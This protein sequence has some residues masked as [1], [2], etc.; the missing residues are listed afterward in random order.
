MK[1]YRKYYD[2]VLRD[3]EY[4]L[5]KTEERQEQE[6]SLEI[7]H[8]HNDKDRGATQNVWFFIVNGVI[9]A[10]ADNWSENIEIFGEEW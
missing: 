6:L 5:I 8:F 4:K 2:S 3:K 1:E 10:V 9:V 7:Q